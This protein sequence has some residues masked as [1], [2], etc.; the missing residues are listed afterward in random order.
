MGCSRTWWSAPARTVGIFVVVLLAGGCQNSHPI[1]NYRLIEHQAL[2]DF[3]GLQSTSWREP[4]KAVCAAPR[5]WEALPLQRTALFNHQQWRSPS[6]TTGVGIIH[7][8]LPLPL[9]TDMVIWLAKQKYSQKGDDGR[10]VAEWDDELDRHWFEAENRR[11]HV[12][13]YAV[14]DGID[15]WFVYFGYKVNR[16]MHPGEIAVAARSLETVVP[17]PHKPLP[18]QPSMAN[19]SD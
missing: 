2:V 3:S 9:N 7:V 1:S 6:T 18:K 5:D 14:V 19:G 13:G 4:I 17:A 12:R 16:P 10:V 15:A 8:H 11:Y